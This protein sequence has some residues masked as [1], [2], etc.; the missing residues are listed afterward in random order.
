MGATL[1][2]KHGTQ[3]YTSQKLFL[4]DFLPADRNACRDKDRNC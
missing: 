2:R 1:L 4:K 3:R